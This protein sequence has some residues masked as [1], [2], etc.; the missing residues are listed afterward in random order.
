MERIIIC[1]TPRTGSNWFLEEIAKLPGRISGGEWYQHEPSRNLPEV[2]ENK[3]HRPTLCNVLKVFYSDMGKYAFDK[4]L[5][6]R[7][8]IYLYREDIDAQLASW[9]KAC[10]TGLWTPTSLPKPVAFPEDAE[11]QIHKAEELFSPLASLTVSYE[12]LVTSMTTLI[13]KI[14]DEY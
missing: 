9:K 5:Q 13:N 2:L 10:E 11:E 1:C 6:S 8:L 14:Q 12:E 7:K 4:L 3:I